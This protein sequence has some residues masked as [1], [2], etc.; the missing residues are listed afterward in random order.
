M[1]WLSIVVQ[2]SR[3]VSQQGRTFER[4]IA[5][6]GDICI[7]YV[8]CVVNIVCVTFLWCY[9]FDDRHS[10]YKKLCPVITIML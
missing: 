7:D 5:A 1:N 3:S 4:G 2:G 8:D 6:V 9:C 10:V